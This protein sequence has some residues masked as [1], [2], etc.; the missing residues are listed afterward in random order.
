MYLYL[1]LYNIVGLRINVEGPAGWSS[2][3]WAGE[4]RYFL[5]SETGNGGEDSLFGTS[6]NSCPVVEPTLLNRIMLI[7]GRLFSRS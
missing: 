3:I 4:N 1:Y 5:V 7:I 6:A 2:H